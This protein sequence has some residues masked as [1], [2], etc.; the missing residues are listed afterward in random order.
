MMGEPTLIAKAFSQAKWKKQICFEEALSS[1]RCPTLWQIFFVCFC[2]TSQKWFLL[3]VFRGG[4][5][6]LRI[7]RSTSFIITQPRMIEEL[8]LSPLAVP[9]KTE[10][11]VWSETVESFAIFSNCCLLLAIARPA[12]PA[13]LSPAG[14]ETGT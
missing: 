4:I 2:P 8:L 5:R 3:K 14:T 9:N 6:S 7:Q 10:T 12:Y 11:S 1:F 13:A